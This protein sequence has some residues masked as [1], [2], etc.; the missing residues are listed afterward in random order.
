M[1]ISVLATTEEHAVAEV[2]SADETTIVSFNGARAFSVFSP[3]VNEGVCTASPADSLIT[4]SCARERCLLASVIDTLVLVE[5][6]AVRIVELNVLGSNRAESVGRAVESNIVNLALAS[7]NLSFAVHTVSAVDVDAM[8]V[9]EINTSNQ[10]SIHVESNG[11]DTSGS[12]GE[13]GSSFLLASAGVPNE[14]DWDGAN[15]SCGGHF[16]LIA[17]L[18]AHDVVGVSILIV[19]SLLRGVFDLTTSEKL[20]RV[21]F[22]IKNDTKSS[23][24]VASIAIRIEVHV[25]SA[26][27]ASVSVDVF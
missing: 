16:T 18:E 6:W 24:H 23:S 20:L 3:C 4:P 7:L 1:D 22:L 9:V 13:L 10:T 14:D 17:N 2:N 15:L 5:A 21:R 25:L 27:S 11:I 8:V 12:F 26:V 19:G